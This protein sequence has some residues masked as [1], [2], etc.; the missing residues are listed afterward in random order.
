MIV[1][2][3]FDLS[4]NDRMIFSFSSY[5]KSVLAMVILI[6]PTFGLPLSILDHAF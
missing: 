2:V 1:I 5:L 4:V 3:L 6:Q